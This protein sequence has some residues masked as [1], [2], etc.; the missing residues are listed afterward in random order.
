M[1]QECG[2]G[3]YQLPDPI[4][5]TLCFLLFAPRVAMVAR[6]SV[7]RIGR[8]LKCR[9]CEGKLLNELVGRG[10]ANEKVLKGMRG[11]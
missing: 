11:C 2:G 10:S 4:T 6:G 3:E 8:K 7:L 5:V 9:S 1:L